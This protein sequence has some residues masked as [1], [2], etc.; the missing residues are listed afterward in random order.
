MKNRNPIVTVQVI[1]GG[2]MPPCGKSEKEKY[3]EKFLSPMEICSNSKVYIPSDLHATF[4]RLV[5]TMAAPGVSLSSYITSILVEHIRDN[6]IAMKG[7]YDDNQQE[8]FG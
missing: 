1:S 8:L 6:A 2:A 5:K 7:I 4:Q 3:T